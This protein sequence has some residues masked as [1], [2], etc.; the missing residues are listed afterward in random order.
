MKQSRYTERRWILSVAEHAVLLDAPVLRV[1]KLSMTDRQRNEWNFLELWQERA[2]SEECGKRAP[3]PPIWRSEAIAK[4]L[5]W[6]WWWS[7]VCVHSTSKSHNSQRTNNTITQ[8]RTIN[9]HFLRWRPTLQRPD[10][11]IR[12]QYLFGGFVS[13]GFVSSDRAILPNIVAISIGHCRMF[14]VAIVIE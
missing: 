4:M 8:N 5:W 14:Q 2:Q 13:G 3:H 10:F 6:F 12:G 1:N 9:A 7:P 11:V